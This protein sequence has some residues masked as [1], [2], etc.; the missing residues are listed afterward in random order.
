LEGFRFTWLYERKEPKTMETFCRLID[1][2]NDWCGRIF[3]WLFFPLTFFVVADVFTRYVLNRP[4]FY[5]DFSIQVAGCLALLG[6]GY[7]YLHNGHVGVDIVV[8]KLA[9]KTRA[10]LDLVL[11]PLF[12]IGVGTLLWKTTE[13]AYQSLK[14][15]DLFTSMLELP[16]YPYRVII[17][18]GVLLLLLQGVSKFVHD[19]G[20]ATATNK[21]ANHEH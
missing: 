18:V 12:F 15:Q 1:N 17:V 21:Q 13:A 2:L 20:L 5:I 6:L 19:L 3:A 11:F 14:N 10:I 8:L 4:W 7:T 16:E 9:P